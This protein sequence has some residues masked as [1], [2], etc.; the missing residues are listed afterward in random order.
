[1]NRLIIVGNGFDLAHGLPT[2]YQ[3]FMD[4]FWESLPKNYKDNLVQSMVYVDDS[5]KGYLTFEGTEIKNYKDL[6]QNMVG[7]AKEYSMKFEPTQNILYGPTSR[8]TRIFQFK[9][10]FFK[11]LTLESVD[12]WV[13]IENTYYEI[14]I[15]IVNPEKRKR[16]YDGTILKLNREFEDVKSMLEQYLQLNVLNVCDMNKHSNDSNDLLKYFKLSVFH[17]SKFSDHEYF[18]E[19]PPEDRNELIE[20]DNL[21]WKKRNDYN[22][23]DINY[24]PDNLFLNFN[25]TSSLE[26]YVELINSQNEQYG[27][28]SQIHIHG[29]LNSTVNTI[30]FGFGDEMDDYYNVIEKTND[31]EYLKNIKSFQYL[32]TSNYRKLLNWIN[33]GKKFQVYI[34]G[35]SCGLSDRTLLN[36]IFENPNCRSIKIFYHKH[37]DGDNYT[38]IT[39]NI[40]RH[41]N[42]KALMREKI[43]DK[44]LSVE[45]PQNIRFPLKK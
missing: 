34:F 41:F 25:Y 18:N 17:L 24:L 1:M 15:G 26:K 38:E 9:N 39:Q 40:S 23:K 45:L 16:K 43:V 11:I 14:L 19:F 35:H 31:N 27:T 36:S 33:S 5:Y 22:Q 10:E 32:H 7:Y 12:K 29:K 30:N 13:D 3:H 2:S 4:N 42:K 28:A 8:V 37:K 21:L 6:V 44:T 20:F